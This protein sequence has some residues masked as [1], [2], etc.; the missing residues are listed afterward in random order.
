MAGAGVFGLAAALELRGRGCSVIVV[1]PGPVP[2][3]LAAS[4]DVSRMVRMDYAGDQLYSDLAA[5]AIEG[6]HSWNRRRG[7]PLYHEDGFLVLSSQPVDD[8]SVEGQSF[9]LLTEAGWPLERVDGGD[10]ARRFPFWNSGRY[11]GG[12]FNPRGGWA[13]AGETVSFMAAE[14]VA[15]GVEIRCGFRADGV[16]VESGRAVGLRSGDGGEVRAD[17]VVAAAGVWTPRLAP[18]LGDVMWP[19]A[20]SLLYFRPDAPERFAPPGFPPWAAD[21]SRAG[22][23]G[24]PVNAEGVVK[25]ANHG[26]GRRVDADAPREAAL[27]DIESCRSF[28]AQALPELARAPLAGSR[29]CFYCDTWDGN[30]YI[31]NHPEIEGLT[32]ATGGSGHAF[33]FA[34]A[35][36]RVVADVVQ[37]RDNPYAARFAWRARG[38]ISGEVTRYGGKD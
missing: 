4:N 33:K 24:F 5:E 15:A 14:A 31:A 7:R 6:W 20:Q 10:V 12:Y 35:I 26:P 30:F 22:W 37:G 29:A 32:V 36:G 1:D 21:L 18:E 11:S 9:G 13:E 3:P 17:G 25:V 16:L 28:L 8:G 23:Y 2:H 19:V 34:P 38:E 27:A